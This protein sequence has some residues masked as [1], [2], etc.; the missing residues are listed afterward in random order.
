M[1]FYIDYNYFLCSISGITNAR[2]NFQV[3]ILVLV[4]ELQV[5][6]LVLW[7]LSPRKFSRTWTCEDKDKDL[8]IGPWG[9]SRTR[10][11]LED[12]TENSWHENQVWHEIV[13]QGHSRIVRSKPGKNC[14]FFLSRFSQWIHVHQTT[15]FEK[16]SWATSD[17]ASNSRWRPK[18]QYGRQNA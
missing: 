4:L 17:F 9:S 6:V 3:L 2:T 8:K 13:I 16:R 15:L 1:K 14:P 7:N 12:D 18:I 10:T 5:L 11:L